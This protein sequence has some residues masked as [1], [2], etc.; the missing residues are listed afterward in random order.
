MVPVAAMAQGTGQDLKMVVSPHTLQVG[1]TTEIVLTISGSTA[2]LG[3][4]LRTGDVFEVY[5]DLRG[6]ALRATPVLQLQGA[7]LVGQNLTG[8]VDG[9]GVLRLVYSGPGTT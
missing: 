9:N 2:G 3:T 4:E 6:G 1:K 7:G 5:T 8:Q